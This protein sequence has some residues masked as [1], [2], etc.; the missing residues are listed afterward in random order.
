MLVTFFLAGL[1]LSVHAIPAHIPGHVD[2]EHII[3]GHHVAPVTHAR[4][5]AETVESR[6]EPGMSQEIPPSETISIPVD[7]DDG[8]E[9]PVNADA[10]IVSE[11]LPAAPPTDLPAAQEVPSTEVSSSPTDPISLT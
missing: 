5:V 7:A 8:F 6:N 2:H 10:S 11:S 1:F 9:A 4:L 3:P